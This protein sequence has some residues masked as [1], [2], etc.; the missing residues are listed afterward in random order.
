[1]TKQTG[2][3]IFPKP[4]PLSPRTKATFSLGEWW[5]G[6]KALKGTQTDCSVYYLWFEYLKRSERYKEVCKAKGKVKE[7][8]MSKL[9]ED[10]G[11]IFQFEERKDGFTKI[12]AFYD[13]WWEPCGKFLFGVLAQPQIDTFASFD[14]LESLQGDIESGEVKVIVVPTNMAK[15]KVRKRIGKLISDLE[16]TPDKELRPKYDILSKR[17]D[18]KSLRKCLDVYD[19]HKKGKGNREIFA[20]LIGLEKGEEDWALKDARGERG[21]LQDWE[22]PYADDYEDE[23]EL[24]DTT[25]KSY[26]KES[27]EWIEK[28][29]KAQRYANSRMEWREKQRVP[30]GDGEKKTRRLS[31]NELK[32][33]HNIYVHKKLGNAVP[34]PQ[35]E[36]RAKRK[37]FMNS[38]ISRMIKKAKQNI[39]A[40]EKGTFCVTF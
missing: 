38:S 32:K 39:E 1:M 30:T 22:V 33:L 9:Y 27:K 40:V 29:E 20:D 24:F 6:G 36:D 3:L 23:N 26:V 2:M 37:N 5:L 18:A 4:Q 15:T 17:V 10:F 11:D 14:E 31:E 12:E 35:A 13:E 25:S 28:V 19:L 21:I 7:L 34:T 8:K 16:V